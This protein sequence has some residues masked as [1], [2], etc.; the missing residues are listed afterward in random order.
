MP[1]SCLWQSAAEPVADTA[2]A[3]Q[4]SFC[5]ASFEC[6]AGDGC[7]NAQSSIA[8]CS[9]KVGR[10]RSHSQRFWSFLSSAGAGQTGRLLSGGT[11]PAGRQ[12]A[13]GVDAV[14]G[15]N[16]RMG[17][18]SGFVPCNTHICCC[19][20]MQVAKG[21][22]LVHAVHHKCDSVEVCL[23]LLPWCSCLSAYATL[24]LAR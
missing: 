21:E 5:T 11:Q 8:G 9:S 1:Y 24:C 19:A 16:V 12:L 18:A 20:L 22:V 7:T 2:G 6:D 10:C 17:V 3:Q 15:L 4:D 13:H 23:W 14:H